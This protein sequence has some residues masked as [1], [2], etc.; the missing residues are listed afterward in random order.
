M[1]DNEDMLAES[2]IDPA[3]G[4]TDTRPD[5]ESLDD[6]HER[7][8]YSFDACA[9]PQQELRAQSLAAR[10]F[11]D[12]PGAQWEDIWLEQFEN[13]PRPEV[14]KISVSLNKIGNDYRQNRMMVDFRPADDKADEDTADFCDGVYRAD[15][16][17]CKG[18]LAHDNAFK[19]G[20]KGGFG[21]W[22]MST[23]YADPYDKDNDHQRV[24][25]ALTIPDADQRVYFVNSI[26]QDGSDATAAFLIHKD[27]RD[28]AE[29]KWGKENID[30]FPTV[31]F[32]WTWDWYTPET[33]QTAEYYEVETPE[34]KLYIFTND[35]TEEEQRFFKSE[36]ADGQLADM[37]AQGWKVRTR[38]MQRRRIHKYILNGMKVLK[39][40]GYIAG[41]NI[42]I[43]PFYCNFGYTDGLV[44]WQGYVQKRMDE[45]RILNAQLSRLVEI[46]GSSAGDI[47]I[48]DPM[49][50]PPGAAQDAWANRNIGRPAFLPALALRNDDGSVVKTDIDILAAPQ[51]PPTTVALL[52][53]TLGSLTEQNDNADQVKANVSAEAMDI[54]AQR[55]DDRSGPYLDD[56]NIA[57]QREGEIYLPMARA[58][59]CEAGRKVETSDVD[60]GSD[61]ATLMEPVL[62]P[63]KVFKIRN[64]LT[65][66]RYKVVASVQESTATKRDKTVRQSLQVAEIAIQAQQM[67]IAGAA[68]LNAV[69]NQDGEGMQKLQDFAHQKAVQMGLDKPTD[70]ERAEMESAAQNSK[71][72]P[73][74]EALTATAA[75]ETSVAKLNEAK[76]EDT[77]ASAELKKAQKDALGGPAAAPDVP[78]G[79]DHATGIADAVAKIS[80]AKLHDAQARKIDHDIVQGHH[81]NAIAAHRADT[82]RKKISFGRDLK[83][84]A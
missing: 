76:V 10:R 31:G 77:L 63:D 18:R 58:C 20:L 39:D 29:K 24:L 12:I 79:L 83:G 68:I 32:R 27:P 47:P 59:Y 40:C 33:V 15:L 8:L 65:T 64:D 42:P 19:E 22:R 16:Y 73:A 54:A 53:L 62:T 74:A 49:R 66:G 82:E 36:L 81:S 21:A 23:D 26:L 3:D 50:V 41:E 57:I 17:A 28:V 72:D 43:V 84:D 45:Q 5:G 60:G 61:M 70:E 71:P 75:K 51:A 30:D 35:L 55:V 2:E 7:A 25:P 48:L 44:R 52:Q 67:D 4:D 46:S 78:S 34:E 14:D 9:L 38:N 37:K 80:G 6:V 11:V 13:A 56:F 1:A 69:E